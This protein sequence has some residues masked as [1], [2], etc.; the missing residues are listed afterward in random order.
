MSL[1]ILK[2]KY[3]FS[4]YYKIRL[5]MSTYCMK[6]APNQVTLATD[7]HSRNF[8]GYFTN[9]KHVVSPVMKFSITNYLKH[10]LL[11]N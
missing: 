11:L 6:F 3:Q 4:E 8:N 7:Q 5:I 2:E 1:R 10:S 9:A